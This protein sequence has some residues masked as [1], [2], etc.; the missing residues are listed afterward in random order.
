MEPV[1]GLL[2]RFLMRR[3]IEFDVQ[4]GARNVELAR[5]MDWIPKVWQH[6]N[7]FLEIHNSSE[8]TIGPRLF[9]SCPTDVANSQ[10]WFT[11]L[12]HYSIVPYLIE[13]VKEG[14]QLYGRKA[15]WEDPCQFLLHTYPWSESHSMSSGK[16]ALLRLAEFV[17]LIHLF[18]NLW[19]HL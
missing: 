11:D 16:S 15:A 7:K 5:V 12:W 2:S 13:A 14:I 19:F 3:L 4:N 8:V 6:I 10:V 9:L 1:K 17:Q 18:P